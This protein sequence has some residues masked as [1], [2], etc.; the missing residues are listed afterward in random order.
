M[1]R[2]LGEVVKIDGHWVTIQTHLQTGCGGCKQQ[3]VCGAGVLAKAL[4]NRRGLLDVWLQEPPTVGSQVELL[5]PE[6]AMMQFSVLLYLIPLLSL[7]IGAWF[8]YWLVPSHEGAS[9]A[10][11]LLAFALSFWQL[12]RWLRG[13][14]TR[15]QKLLQVNLVSP[16]SGS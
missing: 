8:G 1:I 15:V 5:L 3:N 11:G 10:L 2:E 9:I 7:F 6:K 12:R 14:D 16:N 4:P 13:R